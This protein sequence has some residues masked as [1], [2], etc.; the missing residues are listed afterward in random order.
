MQR[1]W[2]ARAF[3]SAAAGEKVEAGELYMLPAYVYGFSMVSHMWG[4]LDVANLGDVEYADEA[5]DQ[6]VYADDG[7]KGALLKIVSQAKIGGA[8]IIRGKGG[9]TIVLLKGPTGLG[10]TLTA[11]ALAERLRRP[12]FGVSAGDL[13]VTPMEVERKLRS[14]LELAQAWGAVLLLDEAEV[15]LAQ[16]NRSDFVQIAMVAA[17]LKLL[18][19]YQGTLVLTSNM[20][21]AIDEA[22]HGRLSANISFPAFDEERRARVW[23]TMLAL[24]K[25]SRE[26]VPAW[27]LA[28]STNGRVIRNLIQDARKISL[29]DGEAVSPRHFGEAAALLGIE[30]PGR[31]LGAE[32]ERSEALRVAA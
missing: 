28:H 16:R 6:L 23:A 14:I 1:T 12:L 17:F 26:A 24:A 32:G 8:D 15:Y 13:G 21:F 27:L 25:V 3:R 18:E 19:H 7:I 11:E 10:K 31:G 30:E 20:E 22:F 9:A 29:A 5:F 2:K 4:K